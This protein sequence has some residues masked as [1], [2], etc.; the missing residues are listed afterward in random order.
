[1]KKN[2]KINNDFKNELKVQVQQ[3]TAKLKQQRRNTTK[4]YLY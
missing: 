1:M 2:I 4:I 3:D